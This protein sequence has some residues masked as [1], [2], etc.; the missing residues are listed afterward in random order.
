LTDE[1]Q[2]QQCQRKPVTFIIDELRPKPVDPLKATLE[3]MLTAYWA[4]FNEKQEILLLN[5]KDDPRLDAAFWETYNAI[6]P[7]SSVWFT[8]DE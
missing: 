2:C 6:P 1:C 4:D 5:G 7:G 3:T 8:E